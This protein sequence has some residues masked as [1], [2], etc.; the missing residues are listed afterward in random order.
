[1]IPGGG[2]I[3]RWFPFAPEEVAKHTPHDAK[4]EVGELGALPLLEAINASEGWS[5]FPTEWLRAQRT[6]RQT[7]GAEFERTV[8]GYDAV[9]VMPR[10]HAA[11]LYGA[12]PD[13]ALQRQM[14][15]R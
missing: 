3:N 5:Q 12:K 7:G 10:V 8:F 14:S 11:T 1:V 9:V 6:L 2:E 13:V 4:E 15:S